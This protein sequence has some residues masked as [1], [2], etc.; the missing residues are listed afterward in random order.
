LGKTVSASQIPF[1]ADPLVPSLTM[2]VPCAP[3]SREQQKELGHPKAKRVVRARDIRTPA[4]LRNVSSR[5]PSSARASPAPTEN[6]IRSPTRDSGPGLSPESLARLF[7]PFYT[8]KPGGMGMGLSICRSIINAHGGQIWA[9]PNVPRGAMFQF[10]L[11]CQ[12][13][14]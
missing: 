2:G 13:A 10:S 3:R 4:M 12:A 7:E 1:E 5:L 9:E 14:S 11:P 8:T 6:Y